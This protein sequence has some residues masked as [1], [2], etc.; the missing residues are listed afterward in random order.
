MKS[1]P[2]LPRRSGRPAER[3]GLPSAERAELR[4]QGAKAAV[5]G[6]EDHVNPMDE[7]PNRPS[8]TGECPDVWRSRKDAW[9]EGHDA[10]SRNDERSQAL[11]LKQDSSDEH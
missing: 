9:Q 10:Q 6:E 7:Q 3:D 8:S 1:D 11:P 4:R 5:R 2:G